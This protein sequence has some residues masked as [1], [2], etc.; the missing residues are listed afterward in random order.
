MQ[1]S[2]IR[3]VSAL[4][5][6]SALQSV[7]GHRDC[8]EMLVHD[9][10]HAEKFV[11]GGRYWQQVGFFE[12]LRAT[13]APVHE[14][15]WALRFGHRWRLAWQYV[16]SDMN[17]M[18]VHMLV[19]LK[20]QLMGAVA[21]ATLWQEGLSVPGEDGEEEAAFE[22]AKADIYPKSAS[23]EWRQAL[24]EARLE[25]AYEAAFTAEWRGLIEAH[26]ADVSYRFPDVLGGSS[27]CDAPA[28]GAEGSTQLPPPPAAAE[29]A[30]SS[31]ALWPR[32]SADELAEAFEA[33]GTGRRMA[34]APT[35]RAVE[36]EE[37]GSRGRFAKALIAH[38]D[39]FGRQTLQFRGGRGMAEVAVST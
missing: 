29:D 28:P 1:A 3:C 13:V 17:S 12:F 36:D 37:T 9:L 34:W 8:L 7:F 10:S 27:P 23:G 16:S 30:D 20:C 32:P 22:A 6:E 33:I 18:S 35:E 26:I 4:A 15:R 31:Y 21:R 25:S 38:F 39:E 5:S 2:G 19:T 14:Q 24:K 11:E